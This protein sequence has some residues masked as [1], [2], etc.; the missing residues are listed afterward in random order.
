MKMDNGKKEIGRG[1][2]IGQTDERNLRIKEKE[3]RT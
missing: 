2:K 3:A 1:I